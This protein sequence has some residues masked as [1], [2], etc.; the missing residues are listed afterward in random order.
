MVAAAAPRASIL[1]NIFARTLWQQ[2]T[3]REGHPYFVARTVQQKNKTM[4]TNEHLLAECKAENDISSQ[5][6]TEHSGKLER[7]GGSQVERINFLF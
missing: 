4:N 3:V 7:E 1:P 6:S 5:Q 2:L